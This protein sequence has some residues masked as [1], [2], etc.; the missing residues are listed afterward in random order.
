MANQMLRDLAVVSLF[1][2]LLVASAARAETKI[3]AAGGVLRLGHFTSA[4]PDCTLSGSTVVRV[5]DAPTHGALK[6]KN[7]RAFSYFGNNQSCNAR[8]VDGVTVEYL[9]QRGFVGT[10]IVGLDVIYAGGYEWKNK[11]NIAVK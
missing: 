3:V 7:E 9:P 4:N 6:M 10:D 11:Y 1:G 2:A 8:R 5:T